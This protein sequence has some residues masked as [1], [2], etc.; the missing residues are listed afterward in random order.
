MVLGASR[1]YH[2]SGDTD[3]RDAIFEFSLARQAVANGLSERERECV[4]VSER[5]R[6]RAR[7][8][9]RQRERERDRERERERE[10]ERERKGDLVS[11]KLLL[12][13][14]LLLLLVAASHSIPP[15]P[16]CLPLCSVLWSLTSIL[17]QV[18]LPRRS[19]GNRRLTE[20]E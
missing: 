6:E 2:F 8:N 16:Q 20:F 7:E 5:E 3:F 18:G 10:G 11:A 19:W 17:Y 15:P 14:L 4:C 9:E 1:S 13:L 12:L